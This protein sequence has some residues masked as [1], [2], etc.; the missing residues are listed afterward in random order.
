[1][2]HDNWGVC[3]QCFAEAC[4]DHEAAKKDV[5]ESYGKVPLTH[6][7]EL[8]VALGEPPTDETMPYSLHEYCEFSVSA[9]G[10]FYITYGC[11]CEACDFTHD[12]TH[13]EQMEFDD[14]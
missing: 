1:M 8:R 6:F 11:A 5:E 10:K 13:T 7:D 14:E 3:P 12:Y 4:V 2:S 9:S